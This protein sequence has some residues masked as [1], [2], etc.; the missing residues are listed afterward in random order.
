MAP[1][2]STC[3]LNYNEDSEQVEAQKLEI[4]DDGS[5]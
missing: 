1:T 2:H 4:P 5:F 3:F